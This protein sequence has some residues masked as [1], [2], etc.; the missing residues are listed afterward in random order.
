MSQGNVE[1]LQA[2]YQA[3]S[4][5]DV[6]GLLNH[7]HP[8]VE[9]RPGVMPPDSA[10]RYRGREA[11]RQFL[12]TIVG[13]PWEAVAVEPRE[14]IEC[15]GGRVLSLDRWRFRGRDGIEIERELPNLFTFRRGL[16]SRID[17]FTD[18]AEALRAVG[19]E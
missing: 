7:M 15:E 2:A 4:R 5:G 11:V 8:D 18:R 13:G 17:G 6:D 14:M 1:K 12:V 9:V 3:F 19:R 16:I 10:T